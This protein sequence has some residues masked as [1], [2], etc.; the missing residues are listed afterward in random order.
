MRSGALAEVRPIDT[1]IIV[2]SEDLRDLAYEHRKSMPFAVR[3]LLGGI[4]GGGDNGSRLLSFLLFESEYTKRL[5]ELGYRDAMAHR[6]ELAA[7]VNG[8]EIPRLFAPSWVTSDLTGSFRKL[9]LT[10]G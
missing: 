8:E 9:V 7:F 1:M 10:T 3:S 4:G 2:P 5:I 6:E